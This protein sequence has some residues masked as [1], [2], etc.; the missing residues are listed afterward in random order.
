MQT[1][2]KKEHKK[3]QCTLVHPKT[4][5]LSRGCCNFSVNPVIGVTCIINN[6]AYTYT[7][8]LLGLHTYKIFQ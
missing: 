7:T 2:K 1:T 3:D 5:A 6:L 4:R 8:L